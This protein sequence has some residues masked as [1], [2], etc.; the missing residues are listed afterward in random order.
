M[1]GQQECGTFLWVLTLTGAAVVCLSFVPDPSQTTR[2]KLLLGASLVGAVLMT[3]RHIRWTFLSLLVVLPVLRAVRRL[4]PLH[5]GS[6]PA[7]L[8]SIFIWMVCLWWFLRKPLGAPTLGGSRYKTG[9]IT[10]LLCLMCVSSLPAL[11]APPGEGNQSATTLAI[12]IAGT[13]E[14]LLLYAFTLSWLETCRDYDGFIYAI[15][16]SLVVSSG[17]GVLLLPNSY[18]E[19]S[20]LAESLVRSFEPFGGPN[21]V[22]IILV[23]VYPLAFWFAGRS[24]PGMR[25]VIWGL[26]SFCWVVALSSRSRSTP[27]IMLTQTVAIGWLLR[28]QRWL[29]GL[30]CALAV[31]GAVGL[32]FVPEE[33][34]ERWKDRLNETDM[35]GY[36]LGHPGHLGESDEMRRELQPRLAREIVSR[37]MGGFAAV[38]EEDPE[39][40]Y[41]DVALQ[42][43]WMPVCFMGL[44]HLYLLG[45]AIQRARSTEPDVRSQGRIYA[46]MFGGLILYGATTGANLCKIDTLEGVLLVGASPANYMAV[47]FAFAQARARVPAPASGGIGPLRPARQ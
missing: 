47:V 30:F 35:V 33:I 3:L 17:V 42:L 45:W 32:H 10:L 19:V 46:V 20:Y 41:L 14:S 24:N 22:G 29:I 25:W 34:T 2:L 11:F 21:N 23:L 12:F 36:F 1:S 15:F 18:G 9:T 16:I 5:I 28:E 26:V 38:N 27:V 8:P 7:T 13:A 37:P 6:Y 44:L 4:F 31:S 39:G 43:G 40:L